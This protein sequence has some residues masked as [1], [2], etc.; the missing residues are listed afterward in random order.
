MSLLRFD[1]ENVESYDLIEF[2]KAYVALG[3]SVQEQLDTIMSGNESDFE[4]GVNPNAVDLIEKRLSEWHDEIDDAV[5]A[6][7]T[8][9]E[10][11]EVEV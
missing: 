11:N 5:Q 1:E 2:A 10:R 8:W 7:R 4:D 6:Y 9:A 3:S